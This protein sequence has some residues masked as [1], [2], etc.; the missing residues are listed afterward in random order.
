VAIGESV[1]VMSDFQFQLRGELLHVL[2][3]VL[4]SPPL[5]EELYMFD[6]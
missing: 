2:F 4:V 1:H 6:C 3:Y 5:F